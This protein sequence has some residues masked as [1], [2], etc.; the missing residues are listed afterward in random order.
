MIT[1]AAALALN[2]QAQGTTEKELEDAVAKINSTLLNARYAETR[3]VVPNT[4]YTFQAVPRT[5]LVRFKRADG[6]GTTKRTETIEVSVHRL[7]LNM[8]ITRN[9][10]PGKDPEFDIGL[11]CIDRG[12]CV[13][14]VEVNGRIIKG[15][16]AVRGKTLPL[17]GL[18]NAE[19][20]RLIRQ[21]RNVAQTVR[22]AKVSQ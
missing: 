16:R 17:C 18:T 20:T 22:E 19:T 13:G 12:H 6:Q 14:V 2:G 4:A 3:V 15:Q 8:G 7:E 11:R 5:R 10:R 9:P 21:I 1:A